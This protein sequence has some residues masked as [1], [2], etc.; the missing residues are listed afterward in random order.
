MCVTVTDLFTDLDECSLFGVCL[1][2][3][4]NNTVGSYTCTCNGGFHHTTNANNYIN[5]TGEKQLIIQCVGN[6]ADSIRPFK[7]M[8]LSV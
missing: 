3:I 2:G 1:H 5:S 8:H 4:C 7:I 6:H